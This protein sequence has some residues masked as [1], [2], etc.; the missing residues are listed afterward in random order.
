VD[1]E[2]GPISFQH[3]LWQMLDASSHS[4]SNE[5]YNELLSYRD[6]S[7]RQLSYPCHKNLFRVIMASNGTTMAKFELW[8]LGLLS[9]AEWD[10]EGEKVKSSWTALRRPP[11]SNKSAP[12]VRCRPANGCPAPLRIRI[13]QAR[14]CHEGSFDLWR[15][16]CNMR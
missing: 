16:L 1:L 3:Q 7:D 14:K 8:K 15:V 10:W 13:R 4:T 9:D 5:P 11:P 2:T 12:L 6:C